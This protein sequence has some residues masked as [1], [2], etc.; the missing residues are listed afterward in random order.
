MGTLAP[1]LS[2]SAVI[3]H[4]TATTPVRLE[5][6]VMTLGFASIIRVS[7]AL[8]STNNSEQKA[9]KNWCGNDVVVVVAAAPVTVELIVR[10]R[11]REMRPLDKANMVEMWILINKVSD[12][13]G[14]SQFSLAI[15]EEVAIP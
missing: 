8:A 9:L 2:Q 1:H 10:T 15:I 4:L 13:I 6:G 5:R 11:R 3:P 14:C 12:K 7:L